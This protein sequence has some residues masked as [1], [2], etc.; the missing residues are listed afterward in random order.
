LL[1][2]LVG[3]VWADIP[4]LFPRFA[5]SLEFLHDSG[6][7]NVFWFHHL[8]DKVE[9]GPSRGIIVAFLFLLIVLG[10]VYERYEELE[11]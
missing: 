7:A 10:F 9:A 8:L 6:W 3:G 11:K 4:D 5:P 2:G 1:V